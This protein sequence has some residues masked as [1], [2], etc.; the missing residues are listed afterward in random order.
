MKNN[1]ILYD[2]ICSFCNA[3]IRRLCQWDKNDRLYFAPLVS[4][5]GKQ[6]FEERN[7]DSSKINSII[8]WKPNEMYVTDAQAIFEILNTLGGGWK[9][10]TIFNHLPKWLTNGIY[11]LIAKNRYTWFGKLESCPT[12]IPK[13]SHKFLN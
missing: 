2:G 7:I 5:I 12:P 9:L 11:R 3:W 8:F 13:F 10:I 1:I 6:F 4:N